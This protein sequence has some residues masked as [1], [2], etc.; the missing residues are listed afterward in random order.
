MFKLKFTVE[1]GVL[2]RGTLRRE[3]EKYCFMRNLDLDLKE[4]KG[5]FESAFLVTIKGPAKLGIQVREDMERW[6]TQL[7]EVV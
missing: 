4:S 5:W 7:D 6:R 2:M 1:A 3:L